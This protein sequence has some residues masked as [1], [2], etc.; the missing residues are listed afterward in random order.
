MYENMD[1]QLEDIDSSWLEEFDTLD[2]EYKDFY[3]EDLSF[4]K[5]HCIYINKN[6]EIEKISEEKILLKIPGFL[7]KEEMV[8][9]IK[10]NV[11]CN[12]VKY[13]LL[14]IL[15]F[16]INIDPIYLKTFLKNKDKNNKMELLGNNF[17]QSVKNI[18]TI[19]FDK[20]ISMF[21]DLNDL[22][23]LFYDKSANM[24]IRNSTSKNVNHTKK[25]F[26][27]PNT[28]KKT[29]RNGFKDIHI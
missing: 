7:S 19:K 21:H 9:L 2:K 29:K 4:I 3:T 16:N 14:S 28:L 11:Y 5:L 18:D 25:I 22:L 8:G 15:K 23:I 6:N 27:S 13:S 20:S 1:D 26:L 17:L 24:S 10:H 12:N